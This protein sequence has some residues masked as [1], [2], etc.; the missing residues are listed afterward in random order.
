MDI[1]FASFDRFPAPKGAA[2]HIGQFSRALG[3]RMGRVDLVTV[4][5][6]VE[7]T[8]PHYLDNSPPHLVSPRVFHHPLPAKGQ[9]MI[10]RAMHFRKHLQGFWHDR[11]A[12]VVHFRSIFEG[13]PMVKM[14]PE[15][16]FQIVYE[17]NGLPSIELKYHYPEVAEDRELLQ[18]L[19]HQED[20]CL[21]AAERIVTVSDVNADYLVERGVPRDRID[22]IPNGVDPEVF[23]YHP[24]KPLTDRAMEM[25]YTG[26]MTA[27]QGVYHAIEALAL[28]RRDFPARLTLIGP[29]R[30][31]QKKRIRERAYE[32]GVLEHV[33]LAPP[34]TQRDLAARMGGYDVLVA[35]LLPNDRNQLQGCC[36]LKV[37]EGMA[38][39]LPVI[40]SDL[41]VVRVLARPDVDALLVRPGSA[42]AIKDG[43]LRLREEP[44]LGQRISL[45][46]RQ[47]IEKRFTWKRSCDALIGVYE[48]LKATGTPVPS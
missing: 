4:A 5:P 8:P 43:M 19:I 13:L 35:P 27:W 44:G 30:P 9:H 37:L 24:P 11:E 36:P 33:T 29:A 47:Q 14:K 17:V 45:S 34:T 1:V 25:L 6:A 7:E 46:A 10:Q 15:R 22:V 12:D 26:T 31:L 41:P 42:K 39:G 38:S 16:G 2:V 32:L 21:A 23:E 40:S 3:E 28:Y 20:A 48:S 18:K